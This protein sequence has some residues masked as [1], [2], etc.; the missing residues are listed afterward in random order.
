MKKFIKSFTVFLVVFIF[1]LQMPVVSKAAD[2]SSDFEMVEVDPQ[3]LDQ[4][5]A[6]Y[7]I[8]PLK[9][10]YGSGGSA[11][12]DYVSGARAIH[13]KVKPNTSKT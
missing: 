10:F 5:N 7:G 4:A 9:T 8:M 1:V 12:L 13:W 2:D 11:S 6:E 3:S